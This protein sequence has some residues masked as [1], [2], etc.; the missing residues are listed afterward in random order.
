MF[1]HS[2]S[3]IVCFIVCDYHLLCPTVVLNIVNVCKT[4]LVPKI[5]LKLLEYLLR[6]K[7]V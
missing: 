5:S 2:T 1:F 7:I 6:T 4:S 3:I